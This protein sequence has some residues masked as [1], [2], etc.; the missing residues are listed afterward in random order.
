MKELQDSGVI[1]RLSHSRVQRREQT[2]QKWQMFRGT[3]AVGVLW[4][5]RIEKVAS[6]ATFAAGLPD[7]F[8]TRPAS[9]IRAAIICQ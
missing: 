9:Q 2:R 6:Y 4:A 7:L 1:T 3:V 5:N 8:P